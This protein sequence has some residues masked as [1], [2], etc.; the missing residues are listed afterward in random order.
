M[1]I[2]EGFPREVGVGLAAY[3]V[4]HHAGYDVTAIA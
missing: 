1:L 3:C 2:G 4:A